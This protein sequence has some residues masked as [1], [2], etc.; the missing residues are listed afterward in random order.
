M[1]VAASGLD[2]RV[3]IWV[4]KFPLGIS[5]RRGKLSEEDRVTS[6]VP[7]G[8]VLG[9]L[10]FLAYVDDIWRD[11]ESTIKFFSVDSVIHR[12]I[13]NDSDIET[14]IDLDRM[15]EWAVE[16]AMKI[17]PSK[18]KAVSFT[19]SRVKDLLNYFLGGPNVTGLLVILLPLREYWR[20]M[21]TTG[22]I[23]PIEVIE[24]NLFYF[25]R[26]NWCSTTAHTLYPSHCLNISEVSHG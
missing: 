4:R 7:Q 24:K 14:Q 11:F 12:K 20:G 25:S 17:N 18:S 21:E 9:P 6:G 1:K 26:N 5:Q 13:T 3:A 23:R 8:S 22:K 16:N 15:V 2:S 10:L 19:R